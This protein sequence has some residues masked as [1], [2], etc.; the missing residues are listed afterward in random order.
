M[1]TRETASAVSKIKSDEGM[2]KV[3]MEAVASGNPALLTRDRN[4]LAVWGAGCT[5]TYTIGKPRSTKDGVVT[6]V[7]AK[8]KWPK[9][10]IIVIIVVEKKEEK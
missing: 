1:L 6:P 4:W 7:E 8:L 2:G 5:P 9:I 3:L 10:T